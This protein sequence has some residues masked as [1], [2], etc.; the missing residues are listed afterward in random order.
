MTAS[1]CTMRTVRTLK[2]A[3]TKTS[4]P[5]QTGFSPALGASVVGFMSEGGSG[6]TTN[7]AGAGSSLLSGCGSNCGLSGAD[8]KDP[9]S[10]PVYRIDPAVLE[11]SR[12][13]LP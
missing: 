5:L 10:I 7:G 11:I 8:R 13:P 6:S 2:Q 1:N 3:S 9:L 4:Q 12:A